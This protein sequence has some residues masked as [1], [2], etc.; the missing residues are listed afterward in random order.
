MQMLASL[1]VGAGR[2]T[3]RARIERSV[4]AAVLL[5]LRPNR[6]TTTT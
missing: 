3:L 2:W 6:D 1:L 5:L 4:D